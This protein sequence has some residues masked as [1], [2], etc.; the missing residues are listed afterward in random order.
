MA[1]RDQIEERQKN[2]AN[3]LG[4]ITGALIKGAMS[5]SLDAVIIMFC[6]NRAIGTSFNF[7]SALLLIIAV[8]TVLP[9]NLSMLDRITTT[10]KVSDDEPVIRK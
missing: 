6:V 8:R 5:L 4:E 1:T 2:I 7:W 9:K 3:G 10:T